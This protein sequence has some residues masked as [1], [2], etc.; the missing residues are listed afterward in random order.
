MSKQKPSQNSVTQNQ[1]IRKI[2]A[3]GDVTIIQNVSLSNDTWQAPTNQAE[4]IQEVNRLIRELG[5]VKE[6]NQSLDIAKSELTAAKAAAANNHPTS[7][8]I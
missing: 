4:F 5:S 7:T 3:R 2:E 6:H 8:T 1:R